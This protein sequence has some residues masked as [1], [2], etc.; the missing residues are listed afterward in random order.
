MNI[1]D[2]YIMLFYS[3][4]SRQT[5][6]RNVNLERMCQ[7]M[8]YI[9]G[10]RSAILPS[11]RLFQEKSTCNEE[12]TSSTTIMLSNIGEMVLLVLFLLGLLAPSRAF[13]GR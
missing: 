7:Q 13:R 11:L 3:A 10:W 1:L 2:E 6:V 9:A 4:W 12:V 8:R 5:T